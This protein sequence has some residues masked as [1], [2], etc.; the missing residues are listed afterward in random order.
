MPPRK[1]STAPSTPLQSI[2]HKDTRANIPTEELRD[3]VTEQKD[4]AT[5]AELILRW[6]QA[7]VFPN[8]LNCPQQT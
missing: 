1:K 2:K 6:L 7:H 8:Q 5:K 4:A 3:F